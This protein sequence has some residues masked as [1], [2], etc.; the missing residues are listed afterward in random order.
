MK[1]TPFV[2]DIRPVH[3]ETLTAKDYLKLTID[4]PGLIQKARFVPPGPSANHFG[5][6]VVQYSRARYR[7]P[8]HG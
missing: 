1:K 5:K 2:V 3:S 4:S 7:V 8:A 6:F